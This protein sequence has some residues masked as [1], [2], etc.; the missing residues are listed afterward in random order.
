MDQCFDATYVASPR[1]TLADL[2]CSIEADSELTSA[3]RR[4]LASSI[5]RFADVTGK[6]LQSEASFP[7][8]RMGLIRANPAASG[9][10]RK[11]WSNI[12]SDLRFALERYGA[13]SRAPVRKD[14]SPAWQA[15]RSAVDQDQTLRLGLSN[16]M[17]WC[18]RSGFEPQ[19][20]DDAVLTAYRKDLEERSLKTNPDRVYRQACALWNKA[21]DRFPEWPRQKVTVPSFRQTI[22]YPLPDFPLAFRDDLSRYLDVMSGRDLLAE[23]TPDKPRKTSTLHYHREQIR[24]FASAL[25]H[26]GV[27]IEQVTSLAVLVETNNFRDGLRFYV[28]R[29]GGIKPSLFEMTAT[30]VVVARDYVRVEATDLAE[31]KRMKDKLRCRSRGMTDK[32]R[33]RLRPL[34]DRRNQ[35]RFLNLTETLLD[36]AKKRRKGKKAALLVQTALLHELEMVAPMRFGNLTRLNLERNFR[37][38]RGRGNGPV[39]IVIPEEE[40]KNG[41]M[42]EFELPSRT[43]RLLDR[44]LTEYRPMLLKGIDEGWLFP[45]EKGGHKHEMTLRQQ[46]YRAVRRHTGLIINPHLYRHIAAFFFLQANPGDYETP[47]RLLGHKSIETTITFY[48][49]FERHSA[50]RNYQDIV[51]RRKDDLAELARR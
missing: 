5:R 9:V 50:I 24:R 49:D 7:A 30:L 41:V 34:L 21:V 14:L 47:R 42:L 40:V 27:P 46:I 1:P 22:S 18:S 11:R 48:A 39:Q 16:L 37:F 32:N 19:S 36:E 35:A 38:S 17:H 3:K 44:Y 10:S 33:E 2:F 45:G 8:V 15:L 31:L 4:N 43:A 20:V 25:V 13:P 29:L 12:K 26:S 28:E 6:T 51:L 23:N